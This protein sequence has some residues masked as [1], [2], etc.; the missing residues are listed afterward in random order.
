MRVLHSEPPY[1][2][3][4]LVVSLVFP[5]RGLAGVLSLALPSQRE[6]QNVRLPHFSQEF[7]LKPSIQSPSYLWE[8]VRQENFNFRKTFCYIGKNSSSRL[9]LADNIQHKMTCLHSATS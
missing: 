3:V 1:L 8:T 9:V 5:P 7:Y 4:L 2:L 6:N